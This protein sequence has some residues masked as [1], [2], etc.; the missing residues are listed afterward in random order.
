MNIATVPMGGRARLAG[1]AA[2]D[3]L[4]LVLAGG[5]GSRLGALTNWRAKPAVPFGGRCRIIDFALSNCVNSDIRRILVLTQYKSHSLVKHLLAG[6][7]FLNSGH[8]EFLDIVPAQQWRS[9]ENWYLGTADAV[10]QS[11]D[12]VT[13]YGPKYVIVLAGD[14]IY[15]MDYGEML[16]MHVETGAE[17]TIACTTVPLAEASEFGVMEV[18]AAGR[19]IGFEE[20]PKS[21]KP[22]PGH[23]DRALVSM[24]IYVFLT[25]YL[26]HQLRQD[27]ADENSS[28]DFGKNV[29]PRLL[30]QGYHVQAYYYGKPNGEPQYW[31]DVG[32]VDAYFNAN[33]ELTGP[34]PGL[35]LFNPRWP[36]LSYQPQLPP[37]RIVGSAGARIHSSVLGNGVVIDDASVSNAVISGNVRIHAGCV[38]DRVV[39]LPGC[40][41]RR[42]SRLRN[43]IIDSRCVVPEGTVIG[44]HPE[45]D[46]KRYEVTADGN[47]VVTRQMLGQSASYHPSLVSGG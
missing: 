7:N 1:R 38:L 34:R 16:G 42:G 17:V 36:I 43:V 37:A 14:H 44:E 2:R 46:R 3:T 30:R 6:W 39:A 47:V 13:G 41:V 11:L 18:D 26:A 5:R 28:R 22:M 10:Y 45:E 23:P 4:A 31:R 15:A 32:T 24:G 8:G 21:P 27:A 9:E 29:I 40:E 12:F 33:L 35:D 20:K 25:E 19:I